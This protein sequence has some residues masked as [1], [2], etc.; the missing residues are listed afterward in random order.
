MIFGDQ[1]QSP[2]NQFVASKISF[3]CKYPR[4]WHELLQI[5]LPQALV[6]RE[7]IGSK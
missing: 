1:Q 6:D 7:T 5:V 3:V 4:L 2:S